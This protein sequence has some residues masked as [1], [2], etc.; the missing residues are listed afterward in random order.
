MGKESLDV[1]RLFDLRNT[2]ITEVPPEGF[3]CL[4]ELLSLT[5]TGVTETQGPTDKVPDGQP[6]RP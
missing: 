3:F 6:R 4:G 1:L 2:N 5:V